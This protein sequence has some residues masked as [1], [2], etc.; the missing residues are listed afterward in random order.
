ML[1]PYELEFINKFIVNEKK[2]RIIHEFSNMNKRKDALMRFAHDVD[3]IINK[4]NVLCRYN[5]DNIDIEIKGN[6]YIIS[7]LKL[8]GEC[9]SYEQAIEHLKEQ[10]MPVIIIGD[11]ISI[12]KTENEGL[13]ENIFVLK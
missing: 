2:N 1:N 8:N 9:C 10:Y 12:I 3:K 5:I 7:L 4:N 11:E 6:V 13:K